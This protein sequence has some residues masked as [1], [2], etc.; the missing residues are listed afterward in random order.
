[1]SRLIVRN[2][3]GFTLIETV[4]VVI[5]IGIISAIAAPSFLS[6]YN[7]TKLDD[8]L[9]DLQG[10]LQE[11]QRESMRRSRSCD[12]TINTST[13]K[14]TG[15]CLTT[16]DRSWDSSIAI[17]SSITSPATITFS[18]KGNTASSATFVIYNV[19][20]T[21]NPDKRCL[22]ISEGLG[23]VR[24]GVYSDSN[25]SSLDESKCTAKL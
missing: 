4:V 7:R 18:F 13:R 16:G 9:N 15:T 12:V 23:I 25:V 17:A 3:S 6:S 10:A 19:G 2:D 1:M 20:N 24:T 14:I 11:S 5:F 22:T 8:T 21:T